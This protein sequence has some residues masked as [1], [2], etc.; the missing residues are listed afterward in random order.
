MGTQKR[1]TWRKAFDEAQK[2]C[3]L[4]AKAT[5]EE[6]MEIID[7]FGLSD[8]GQRK[9]RGIIDAEAQPPSANLFR[10]YNEN[11]KVQAFEEQ[12][13]AKRACCIILF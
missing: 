6:L 8:E 5:T 4:P 11:S 12:F 13:A 3:P 10:Y 9:I 2:A 1:E 7:V